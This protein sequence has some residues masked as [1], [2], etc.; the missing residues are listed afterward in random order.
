MWMKRNEEAEKDVNE[1]K[2]KQTRGELRI[3]K[4]NVRNY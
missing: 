1:E 2:F 3:S 4:K